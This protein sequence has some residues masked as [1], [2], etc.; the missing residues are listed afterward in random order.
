MYLVG[1]LRDRSSTSGGVSAESSGNVSSEDG[2]SDRGG[3][4]RDRSRRG[5]SGVGMT[6][7]VVS[8]R[9]VTFGG[10]SVLEVPEYVVSSKQQGVR[11]LDPRQIRSRHGLN[12][13]RSRLYI[14]IYL[15][16]FTNRL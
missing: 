14:S 12:L 13:K 15:S 5:S 11:G 1:G 7:N 2:H 8:S 9:Y 10:D 6:G 3:S 16:I 4:L